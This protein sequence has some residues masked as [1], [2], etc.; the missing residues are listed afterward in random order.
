MEI[1]NEKSISSAV[2]SV[3]SGFCYTSF[4]WKLPA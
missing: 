1:R 4:C 3:V 2:R